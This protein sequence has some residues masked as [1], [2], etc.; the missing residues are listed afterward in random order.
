MTSPRILL[1]LA[2]ASAGL[3]HAQS[4]EAPRGTVSAEIAWEVPLEGAPDA[5]P[6]VLE[7]ADGPMLVLVFG[8]TVEARHAETGERAWVREDLDVATLGLSSD[9][10]AQNF[11]AA[12]APAG[13]GAARQKLVVVDPATGETLL[14]ID[15]LEPMTGA[16]TLVPGTPEDPPVW[17][18]PTEDGCGQHL[19]GPSVVLVCPPESEPL[20]GGLITVVGVP[21]GVTRDEGR[22]TALLPEGG[23]TRP[24]DLVASDLAADGRN[25]YE[26]DDSSLRAHRCRLRRGE[27][28]RCRRDWRQ[29]T[30]ASLFAPPL[31]LDEL[32][33]VGSLDTLVYAFRRR[34]GHLAWRTH[35]GHRLAKPLVE[36]REYVLAVAE[37]RA[38]I[39]FLRADDGTE[40]GIL[41][42]EPGRLTEV[43]TTAPA[44]AGD[45]L[46]APVLVPPATVP[47]LRAWRLS[48]VVPGDDDE[49]A[50]ADGSEAE[51]DPGGTP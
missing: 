9:E 7:S 29:A 51:N 30:G 37:G 18:F 21:A 45:R 24:R 38:L 26:V 13:P 12:T 20:D 40:A 35:A 50:P 19:T 1:I 22:L 16:P 3:A 44:V 48:V 34:N 42:D 25:L 27:T 41:G 32:V 33:V 47:K 6:R 4:D 8:D 46:V 36:W 14:T 23:V 5:P 15:A 10:F 11:V 49:A 31:I 43:L 39:Y 17:V 28:L 2:L